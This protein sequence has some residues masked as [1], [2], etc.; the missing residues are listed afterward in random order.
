MTYWI[1]RIEP[2]MWFE[3]AWWQEMLPSDVRLAVLSLGVGR[4]TP[5]QLEAAH[6]QILEK[7]DVLEREGVDV[8]NVGGSPV[9]TAYGMAGH[10]RLLEEIGA[11]VSRPFV[12]ALQAELEAIR[13]VGASGV[14]VASPY[15]V[16]QTQRRVGI[17]EEEG[18]GVVGAESLDIERNRDIA[19]LDPSEVADFAVRVASSSVGADAVYLPC[20]S[21]PVISVIDEIESR[22]GLPVVA[23]AQAQVAACLKLVDYPTPIE[24]FGR[25]LREV[26]TPVAA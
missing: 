20:G 17:L 19:V 4:L 14:A 21:L 10:A 16:A 25:L 1:G 15:P 9:V 2:S 23:C 26:G 8:I 12:T 7:V 11:R 5:E 6:A 22:T 24:G 13:A 18:F 3:G